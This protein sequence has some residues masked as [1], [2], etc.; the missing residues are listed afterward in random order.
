[1]T[2]I[3]VYMSM[4]GMIGTFVY[5]FHC[6]Y[7]YLC[8]KNTVVNDLCLSI[9]VTIVDDWYLCINVHVV[10]DCFLCTDDTVVDHLSVY[11]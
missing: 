10:Y 3:Y 1:M 6:V 7:F 5:L 11:T 9:H 8:I 4:L 2:V